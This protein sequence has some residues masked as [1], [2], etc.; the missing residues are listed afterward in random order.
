MAPFAVII[1]AAGSSTRLGG[2]KKEYLPL[3]N[4]YDSAGRPLTVLGKTALAFAAFG[5]IETMVITVPVDSEKGESAARAAL[6]A[7]L[8]E[9]G[10]PSVV[11]VPGGKTRRVS[12]HHGLSLLEAYKPSYVLIHDGARPWV[13]PGLIGRV[14]A[15]AEKYGAAIPL[16]P[17]T[18]TPKRN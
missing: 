14:M 6:P 15:A 11:F 7:K 17:F 2:E 4:Q 10:R 3:K 1:T 18:D 8:L 9:A 12:V 16:L 13:S 5:E